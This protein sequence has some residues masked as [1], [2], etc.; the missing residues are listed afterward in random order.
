LENLLRVWRLGDKK[1]IFS[2]AV[3]QTAAWAFH[4]DG[5]RLLFCPPQGGLAIWDLEAGRE[6]KRLPLDLTMPFWMC[7]ASDG[8][9]VAVNNDPDSGHPQVKILDVETGRE[10]ASWTSQVGHDAMA[11]STDGRLV[12]TGCSDDGRVYVWD[13]LRCRLASVLQGHTSRVVRCQFAH[14]GHLLATSA[15]DGT[16]RLWDAASGEA[17]ASAPGELAGPFSPDDRRLPFQANAQL[18]VWE[19]AHGTHCRTLHPGMIGNRTEKAGSSGQVEAGNFSHDGRQLAVA[20]GDGVRLYDN[21]SGK[22]VVY[23][24]VGICDSVLF[25][26]DGQSLITSGGKALYRWP[27]RQT[28]VSGPEAGREKV[29]ERRVG[30][31][32]LIKATGPNGWQKATWMP[33]HRALGV[34]DNANARV[35][36][37]DLDVS[38]SPAKKIG[39]RG[40][41]ENQ[42]PAALQSEHSRMTSIAISPD[43]R[44]AAA[45]G[46]KERVIQVWNLP[47]RRLEKALT[48][49]DGAGEQVFFVAFSPDGRWLVSYTN[50]DEGPGYYF[51]RVGTWVRGL[52]IPCPSNPGLLRAPAF[53]AD[54]R[55][56]ALRLTPRQILLADVATGRTIAHLSTLQPLSATP[57]V[58][59]PDGSRLAASTNQRTVLLW[60]LRAIRRDLTEMKLDWDEPSYPPA[61]PIPSQGSLRMSVDFGDLLVQ[62]KADVA[63]SQ[64]TLQNSLAL[65]TTSIVLCPCHPEGY[66]QRGHIYEELG[67]PREAIEDFTAALRW[68]P[69]DAKRQVHLLGARAQNHWRLKQVDSARADL[70]Q[71]LNLDP[72]NPQLCNN[73]AWFY[74]VAPENQRDPPK[75]LPLAKKAVERS[76]EQWMYRNTLGVVYYRLGQNEAAIVALERSQRE[77]Q[78]AAAAFDLLFLAMAHARMGDLT[79]AK[80]CYEKAI[81]WIQEHESE[82]TP[83]WH[84]ELAQFRTEADVVLGGEKEKPSQQATKDAKERP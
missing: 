32:Q 71:A 21:A 69:A 7:L 49:G 56:M 27:I 60:D 59:S 62:Q 35:W 38:S 58:F 43:G 84:E 8:R 74:V 28:S 14:A 52:F 77:G 9:Q 65:W 34:L 54:G 57:L 20:D 83:Q 48:P 72:E 18:G 15:W 22:E 47:E 79:R 31:P 67:R 64:E 39:S 45:G 78:G 76:G 16:T 6:V 17:L 42:Q 41:L 19:V 13:V 44:W 55:M 73:L 25:H 75:A 23:L 50:N 51:W 3:Q 81:K 12:A 29:G 1:P 36:L 30:P 68:Q 46:W 63:R 37:I 61:E 10:V 33:G 2:Q 11:W 82:L 5:R 40:A 80:N 26:P 4:P 53:T 24:P 70:H 66:H